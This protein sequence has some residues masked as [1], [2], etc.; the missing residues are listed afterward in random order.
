MSDRPWVA[1]SRHGDFHLE[2]GTQLL[3]LAQC[4]KNSKKQDSL[5]ISSWP[6]RNQS[7]KL[8]DITK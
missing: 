6:I 2:R 7:G 4:K 8:Q 5:V 1:Q 3:H